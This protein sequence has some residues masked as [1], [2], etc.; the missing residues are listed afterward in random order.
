MFCYLFFSGSVLLAQRF[1]IK[2]Q[3]IADDDVEGIHILNTS[4]P[5]YTVSDEKGN[6]A[7]EVKL[8]DTLFISS[9][10]YQPKEVVISQS[11]LDSRTLRIFLTEKVNELDEVIVG[12]ILTGSLESDLQNSDVEP[13]IN[14]YDLGIPG[15][16]GKPLTINE[17]KLFDADG[18]PD[19]LSLSGGPFGGGLGVNF[20]KLLNRISG[21]TKKLRLIVDLD[22]RDACISRLR[23][24]YESILFE[25][26]DLAEN[27]RAEYFLY[28]QEDEGF[29]DLCARK[30]DIEAIDFLKLKLNTYLNNQKSTVKN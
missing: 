17:R 16:K 7:I 2:G 10:K 3:L 24:E 26:L 30:N 12:K 5:K 27:L 18:G 20:H 15:F 11:T 4:A 6:F 28:C 22:N 1:E 13:E 23:Q 21:R 14:F 29:L 25:D 8:S 19:I 9:L